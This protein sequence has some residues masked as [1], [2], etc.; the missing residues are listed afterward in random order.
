MKVGR[1]SLHMIGLMIFKVKI[2]RDENLNQ[3]EKK[4]IQNAFAKNYSYGNCEF[5]EIKTK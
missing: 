1:G 2:F 3:T 5:N 4:Q